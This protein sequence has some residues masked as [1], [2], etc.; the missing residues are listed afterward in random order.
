MI[1]R[2]P[3][4]LCSN[5]TG[6]VFSSALPLNISEKNALGSLSFAPTHP[7]VRMALKTGKQRTAPTIAF[8][9]R[10]ARSGTAMYEKLQGGTPRQ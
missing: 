6:F 7:R 4:P 3:S 2:V 5:V 8:T 9:V 1:V 10:E